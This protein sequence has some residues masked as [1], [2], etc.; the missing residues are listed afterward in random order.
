IL[1][2]GT[3]VTGKNEACKTLAYA[4]HGD[5]KSYLN[6]SITDYTDKDAA[7]RLLTRIGTAVKENPTSIILLDEIEKAYDE[8]HNVLLPVIDEGILRYEFKGRYG[9]I[10]SHKLKLSNAIVIA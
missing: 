8:A 2:V 3:T 9:T 1:A 4:I 7:N 6:I 10:T 5:R